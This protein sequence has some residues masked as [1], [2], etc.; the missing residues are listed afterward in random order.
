MFN[1]GSTLS[2][3]SAASSV[4][5]SAV[6]ASA[7]ALLCPLVILGCAA[8]SSGTRPAGAAA[9]PS[10]APTADAAAADA[11][12]RA[13]AASAAEAAVPL[14]DVDLT[15]PLL[16]EIIASEVAVQRGDNGSAYLTLMRAA[17]DTGDPRLARRATEVALAA[18]SASQ[19][20]DAAL[21]WHK[22][23]GGSSESDQTVAALLVANARY[24]EAQAVMQKQIAADPDP[25]AAL[26][27]D[28]RLLSRAP[29]AA[30]GLAMLDVLAKP[31]VGRAASAYDVHLILAH[32]AHAAGQLPR[33]AKEAQEALRLKP[34]SEQAAVSAAQF[35][36]EGKDPDEAAGRA[37][38]IALLAKFLRHNEAAGDARLV[39]ARLLVA[40][41]KTSDART[42]FEDLVKRDQRGPEALFALGLM[43]MQAEDHAGA[44]A[45]FERYLQAIGDDP[46]REPDPAFLNLS[47]IAEDEQKY[48]EAID[49]LHKVRG[50]EQLPTARIRE[51]YILAR[52]NRAND[53]L[54]KLADEAGQSGDTP[55]DRLN[56]T[57]AQG[58]ILREARRYQESYDLLDKALQGA[59]DDPSLLYETA[60]SA[61]RLDK[62]DVMESH[63]RRLVTLR[64][65]YAHAYNALGYTFAD[66]NIRLQEAFELIDKALKL[67]PDDGFI[68]DSMGW[69]QY[70][71]GNLTAARDFLGR[72]YRLKPEADV[73]A[74]LGEVLWN[75]GDKDAARNVFREANRRES[76]NETL[77]E[78]L[79][80]LDVTP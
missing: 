71:L 47:R 19:A 56:V 62:L 28:E 37:S 72:A 38:A 8:S 70:R 68:L 17:Q 45:Y 33:A 75:Q 60:M 41:G 20:M 49:W 73:A 34:D 78:T 4:L 35:M 61:E 69:V 12:G 26:A 10:A 43:A 16:F 27:R 13:K 46:E 53:A 23:D 1:P 3:A 22:L 48:D 66:R 40:D 31:Y 52:T 79:H 15:A 25:V 36:L 67:A 30:K 32:G 65:D 80:R 59:G 39:Y 63:L 5:A 29:D 7:L 54:K 55:E 14:P 6:R 24:D 51:A 74:H 42:Q 11:K 44:R 21:L 18:R 9:A 50:A 58:Q 57:L 76:D 2:P 77:K 64:P